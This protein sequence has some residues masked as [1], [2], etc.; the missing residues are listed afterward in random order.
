MILF[1]TFILSSALLDLIPLPIAALGKPEFEALYKF[2]H[3]NP[4]QVKLCL[5]DWLAN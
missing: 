2:T 4:I 5:V 3:F 1:C